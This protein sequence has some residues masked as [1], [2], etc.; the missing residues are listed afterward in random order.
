MGMP[1][2]EQFRGLSVNL[3]LNKWAIMIRITANMC[4]PDINLLAIETQVFRVYDPHILSVDIAINTAQGFKGS[5]FIGEF[6]VSKIAGVPYFVAVFKMFENRV[7]EVTVG[8]GKEA[9]F[10]HM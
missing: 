2:N 8:I 9:Y 3:T 6:Y 10:S 5:E 7:V 4:H 1:A